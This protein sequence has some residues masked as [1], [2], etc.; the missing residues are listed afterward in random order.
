MLAI[1]LMVSALALPAPCIHAQLRLR[2]GRAE[3]TAGTVY[4]PL[5]FTN[6]GWRAFY[7]PLPHSACSARLRDSHV[8]PVV[9]GRSGL[10]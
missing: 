3:G 2:A 6:V 1:A 5:I 4:H 8:R 9:A 7:A 10:A